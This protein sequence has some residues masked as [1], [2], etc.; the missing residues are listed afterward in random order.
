MGNFKL[1]IECNLGFEFWKD[2]PGFEGSYQEST[3]GRTKSL[4]YN[5]TGRAQILKQVLNKK[6]QYYY[7]NLVKD[8]VAKQLRNARLVGLTFLSNIHNY[9]QINHKNECRTNDNVENLEWC[10]AGYNTN[11]GGHNQRAAQN[12]INHPSLSKPVLQIDKK[13]NVIAE[14]P[15]ARE[16]YRLFGYN[17]VHIDECCRGERKTHMGYIWKFKS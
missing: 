5:H 2:I 13:G 10:T 3:Y 14:F 12:K 7:V 6:F 4:N 9:P 16:A 8:G 17:S 11:Y 1:C 15:S